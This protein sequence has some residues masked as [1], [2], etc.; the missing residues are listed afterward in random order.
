MKFMFI[1]YGTG[2]FGYQFWDEQKLKMIHS[3][4]VIFNE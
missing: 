4:A 3:K 1:G 2:N